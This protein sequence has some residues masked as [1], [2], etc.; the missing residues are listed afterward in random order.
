MVVSKKLMMRMMVIMMAD[1]DDNDDDDGDD[2]DEEEEEDNDDD[3][4]DD[5][6]D[7]DDRTS[8]AHTYLT[9]LCT[10]EPNACTKLLL[11]RGTGIR[12]ERISGDFD[13]CGQLIPNCNSR[14]DE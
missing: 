5:D 2:D 8:C 13:S 4:D 9:I 10:S 3:D 14:E 11:L 1:D 12:F 7:L 6:D